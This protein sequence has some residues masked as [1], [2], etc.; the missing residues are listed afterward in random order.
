MPHVSSCRSTPPTHTHT[1]TRA[2]THTNTHTNTHRGTQGAPASC[3]ACAH[4][5]LSPTTPTRGAAP[6]Q[7]ALVG[8]QAAPNTALS[9]CPPPPRLPPPS[10]SSP[11]SPQP[12]PKAL[13]PPQPHHHPFA[14][15]PYDESLPP[16]LLLL[17]LALT[18]SCSAHLSSPPAEKALHYHHYHVDLCRFLFLPPHRLP[19]HLPHLRLYAFPALRV[20]RPTRDGEGP[21]AAPSTHRPIATVPTPTPVPP[22]SHPAGGAL[23]GGRSSIL[24]GEH[25]KG[26]RGGLSSIR[27]PRGAPQ[28]RPTREQ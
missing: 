11:P 15:P 18:K 28:R 9:Y 7:T 2:N 10:P 26:N 22:H 21:Q 25:R 8:R 17:L 6:G 20:S 5:H 3:V 24:H 1:N 19:R 27:R 14:P 12:P 4:A 13:L 16:L 23:R